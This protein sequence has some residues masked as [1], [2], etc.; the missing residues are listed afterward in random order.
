LDDQ[1]SL[2]IQRMHGETLSTSVTFNQSPENERKMKAI[3]DHLGL[4]TPRASEIP[5]SF[6]PDQP[7][8]L[9]YRIGQE[10]VNSA[11]LTKFASTIFQDFLWLGAGFGGASA[12]LGI[13][14]CHLTRQCTE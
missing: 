13:H 5:K 10:S 9:I 14:G 11:E 2:D 7:V 6:L 4:Q 12:F 3:F 8:Q 1:L